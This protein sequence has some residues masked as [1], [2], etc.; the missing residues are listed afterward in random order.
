MLVRRNLEGPNV[1]CHDSRETGGW[2]E[3]LVM[4]SLSGLT[5]EPIY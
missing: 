5:V 2:R 3:G 4:L 1:L